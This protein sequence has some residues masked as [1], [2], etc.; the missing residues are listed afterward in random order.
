MGTNRARW[1]EEWDARG[2]GD[3]WPPEV[4]ADEPETVSDEEAVGEDDAK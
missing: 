1:A 4:G 3:W 2:L